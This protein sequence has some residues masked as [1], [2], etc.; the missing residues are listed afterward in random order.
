MRLAFLASAV[1][2]LI[3]APAAAQDA[4]PRGVVELFTSQGCSSCPPADRLANEL[5]HDHRTLVLTLP[6][7]YWD[8]LGWK[9]TLASPGNTARQQAYSRARGDRKVYTPQIVVNGGEA[10]VGGDGPSVLGAL[11]RAENA[12]GLALPV[13]VSVEDGRIEVSVAALRRK[14][15]TM[16]AE[17]WVF[18]LERE[19]TVQIGRGENAGRMATYANVVR[20]MTRLGAWDGAPAKFEIAADE[21]LQPENDGVAV[22]VQSGTGGQPGPILG[23][24]QADPPR[25]G[26]A[27]TA[28]Q[29]AREPF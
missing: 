28:A 29:L 13:S 2:V 11:A 12:G 1:V 25:F 15:E 27:T 8:Y 26:A 19:R 21:V 10:A 9:D 20:H 5:S 3:A 18:A 17:V 22:L 24:A 16:H 6:V 4:P 14:I 23:A 7:D